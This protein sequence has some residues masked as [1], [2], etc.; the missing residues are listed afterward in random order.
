[1][2]QSVS[3]RNNVKSEDFVVVKMLKD[4]SNVQ[5]DKLK[6]AFEQG[7]LFRSS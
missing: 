4:F 6:A 7:S 3:E 1:L 5:K 2:E